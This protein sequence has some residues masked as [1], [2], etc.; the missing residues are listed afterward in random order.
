[1]LIVL[2][3][4]NLENKYSIVEWIFFSLSF[5]LVFLCFYILL[6]FACDIK[7]TFQSCTFNEN[8]ESPLYR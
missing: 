4:H 5:C 3:C 8:Q 2:W 6:L 7:Q 1:M